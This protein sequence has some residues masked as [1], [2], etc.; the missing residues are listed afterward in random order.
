MF[1]I[2]ISIASIEVSDRDICPA[3]TAAI[4]PVSDIAFWMASFLSCQMVTL[5]APIEKS[6]Q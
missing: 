3:R 5:T 6:E 1:L 4:L 2:S